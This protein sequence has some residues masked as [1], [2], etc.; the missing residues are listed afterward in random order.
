[1]ELRVKVEK[2]ANVFVGRIEGYPEVMER[3]LTKEAAEAKARRIAAMIEQ[4]DCNP[5][6]R[7][8]GR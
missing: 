6:R 5:L 2:I 3:A 4:G 1:M 8:R 7:G